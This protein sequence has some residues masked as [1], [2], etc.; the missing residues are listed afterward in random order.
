MRNDKER[1]DITELLTK[2]PYIYSAD[3]RFDL[4]QVQDTDVFL[5]TTQGD[6]RFPPAISRIE[7]RWAG[8]QA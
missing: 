5:R 8:Q 6:L 4:Q 3:A 2:T 1:Q 7:T